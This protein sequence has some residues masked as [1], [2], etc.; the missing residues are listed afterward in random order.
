[1]KIQTRIALLFTCI[2]TFFVAALSIA[3]YYFAYENASRD[4]TTRLKLRADVVAKVSFDTL[5]NHSAAY[6]NMRR[7]LLQRLP[8]EKEYII[9]TDTIA[10]LKN[11]GFYKAVPPELI[12]SISINGQTS[13][14]RGFLYYSG[15]AYSSPVSKYIIIVAAKNI[16]IQHFLLN[17]RKILITAFFVGIIIIFSVGL[18]FSR[19]ILAPIRNIARQVKRINATSLHKRLLAKQGKDEISTLADTFNDMLNRL[20]T[21]FETQNNFVSNASHELNTPLTVIIGE[22]DYALARQRTTEQ[23]QQALSVIMQQG[24]KLKAITQSLVQLAQ[25]G[26]T[27][28]FTMQQVDVE[29]LLHNA[30]S[31]AHSVYADTAIKTDVS[32][33]PDASQQPSLYGNRQLLELA[34]SNIVLN[35]C[36]YS[37]H[38]QVTV[39]VALSK[40]YL[41]FIVK[42]EGIGI[43]DEEIIHI[44]D[45]FFRASNTRGTIGYGIGLP[46]VQNIIRLH[47]GQ[48]EIHSKENIGTEVIIKLPRH[49]PA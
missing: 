45:P 19:Q 26:F 23:Y 16:D 32:L 28:N 49:K 46:L 12:K 29:E 39:G 38:K 44:F 27:G 2:C 18:F 33:Y 20:E 30:I 36:K 40:D 10:R 43:P 25:S 17:L 37:G 7:Q 42:D 34:L 35:A 13:Y 3:V 31:N 6:E 9:A 22:A 15:M 5:G 47:K 21:A 24:E 1:M 14:R 41:I 48:I 8:E 4:F 11:S